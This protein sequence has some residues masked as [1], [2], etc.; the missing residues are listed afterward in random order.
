MSNFFHNLFIFE[1]ANN[2][3]GDLDHG[4]RIIHAMRD[5]AQKY[6]INASVKLQYRDLDTFIHPDYKKRSDVKHIPRFMSTRL[7]QAQFKTLVDAIHEAG[8]LRVVTPFDEASVE[9]CIKHHVDVLKVA[10]SSIQDWPLLE[11]IAVAGKPV[12]AS[13]GGANEEE[14][15]N[16]VSFFT[17]RNVDFALL[18][19]VSVYPTP[20]NQLQMDMVRRLKQRYPMIT[21][22]YS[23]HE[24]PN[25]TTPGSIAA[26]LGAEILE[27]HVA[28]ATEKHSVNAYS[29]TPEQT[30][31]WVSTVT[32][33]REALMVGESK[34]VTQEEV[35]SLLSLQRGVYARR[36]IRKG[37]PIMRDDVFFAMPCQPNQT[38]AGQFG[39][40]RTKWVA[41]Q[42]YAVNQP[43]LEQQ[44]I[45]DAITR[46]R[47]IIH[48]AKRMLAEAGI[49]LGENFQVELSHHYGIE[50]FE[51]TGALIIDLVNREY[52][53]K[54]VVLVPGQTHPNHRHKVKEETFQLLWGDLDLIL[55]DVNTIHMKPGD[56]QLIERGT[57]HRF[58]SSGGAIFEEVSTT[59]IKGDSYYEDAEIAR[60]DLIERKTLLEEW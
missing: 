43:I 1:M 56:L 41:S 27:R 17:H 8:M 35:D 54:L 26:A 49:Q 21:I 19:C 58:S 45:D 32:R 24:D 5:I 13:T 14:I 10:S 33:T 31:R 44:S 18:H 47:T 34:A 55:N 46:V 16:V 12:I 30:D 57:W 15:D 23:G 59:H 3:Q 52:C 39:R 9:T 25:D 28:I 51:H 36:P 6:G 20:N 48:R 50:N 29:M 22:G 11:A 40:L 7:E 38:D 4:L 60:K 2:H 37:D 53:K 42:D